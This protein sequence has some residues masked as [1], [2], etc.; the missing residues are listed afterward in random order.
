MRF[1]LPRFLKH[2]LR[3][4][5][6]AGAAVFFVLMGLFFLW[7]AS[8]KIPDVESLSSRKVTQ[9]AKIYDRT[10]TVLLYDLNQDTQRTIV[11]FDQISLNVK[12]AT[13]AIEDAQFYPARW[14]PPLVDCPRDPCRHPRDAPHRERR[15]AGRLDHHAAGGQKLDPDDRPHDLAQAE[16]VGTR[17]PPR[18]GPHQG[19]DTRAL[20]ERIA[21][22]RHHLWRRGGGRDFFWRTRGRPDPGTIGLPRRLAPGAD[23]LLAVWQSSRCLGHAQESGAVAHERPRLHHG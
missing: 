12:N 21:V 15:D 22:R 20:P 8:L 17:G 2:P 19:S 1:R 9:S 7:A 3:D 18:A 6:L 16:R 5:I 11:P 13:V 14:H 23:L 4:I 10:G